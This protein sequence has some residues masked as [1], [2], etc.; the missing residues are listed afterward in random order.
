LCVYSRKKENIVESITPPLWLLN[1]YREAEVRSADLLQRL[2]RYIDD[3]ELQIYLTRQL[4]DEARH[5]Q[6][7]TELINELGGR[8]PAARK[9][10]RHY[11][12]RSAGAPTSVL[13]L[14]ALTCIVEERV[15]QRY[16]VHALQAGADARI[17]AM[18]QTLVAD[19][20]W[21]LTGVRDWLAKIEKQEGKTRVA[22]ML[23]H[24][25]PMEARAYAALIGEGERESKVNP[26][27][28][29]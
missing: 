17:V 7:W 28:A 13:E 1:Y 5:I 19:E 16:Q 9:G 21:H 12:Q 22:A 10:Y 3:P 18:L 25:R 29:R 23:D 27:I 11:L 4:A 14:L 15:Q 6:L 20:A 24:Y 8:L 26:R 2:L